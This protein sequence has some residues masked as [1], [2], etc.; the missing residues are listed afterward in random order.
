MVLAVLARGASY[1]PRSAKAPTRIEGY[2]EYGPVADRVP[3][4]AIVSYK[5]ISINVRRGGRGCVG[6]KD[7][8]VLDPC[9]ATRCLVYTYGIV[10]L[11]LE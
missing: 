6:A 3:S 2:K 10:K 5:T 9:D 8:R 1:A 7:E 11:F 4:R